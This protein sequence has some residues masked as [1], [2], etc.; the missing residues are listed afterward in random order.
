M[1]SM[2]TKQNY[3][4]IAGIEGIEWDA[5]EQP[6]QFNE[7]WYPPC[8]CRHFMLLQDHQRIFFAVTTASLG[9]AQAIQQ[10]DILD[11]CQTLLNR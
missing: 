7:R 1:Q 9:V 11:L 4:S 8:A 2:L 5:V 3:T 10:G 6:S